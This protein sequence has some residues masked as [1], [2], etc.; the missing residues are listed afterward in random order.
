[1]RK[2]VSFLIACVTFAIF[3]QLAHAGDFRPLPANLGSTLDLYLSADDSYRSGDLI[4]QSQLKEFQIYLRRTRGASLATH[5]K[6]SKMALGDRAGLTQ[7]FHNGGAVLFRQAVKKAGNYA[8]L[9]KLART[10]RG[11]AILKNAIK[12]KDLEQ[13]MQAIEQHKQKQPAPDAQDEGKKAP[14]KPEKAVIY[15]AD[16]FLAALKKE[17]AT[18]QAAASTAGTAKGDDSGLPQGN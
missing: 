16:D 4:T 12:N 11:Q 6:W 13:L 18:R 14:S 2:L 1:M 8:D 3:G 7:L 15:T 10:P 9:D 5:Q 17:V